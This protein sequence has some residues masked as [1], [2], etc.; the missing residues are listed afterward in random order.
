MTIGPL[1]EQAPRLI[2]EGDSF[3]AFRSL[4]ESPKNTHS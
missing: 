3:R 4:P 2:L 1:Q